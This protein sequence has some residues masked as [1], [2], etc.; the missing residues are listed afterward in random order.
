MTEVRRQD[1]NPYPPRTI[2]QLLA[3]LQRKM[4]EDNPDAPKFLDRH[5]VRFRMLLRTC[6]SVYRGLHS[7]GVGAQVKHA[8]IF[9]VEEETTLW[10]TG[11]LGD[12]NPTSLQ[13][14]V[15]YY[16]GKVCC[17]RGEDEQRKLGP[18]QFLRAENPDSY[19]Y[20]E[21]GSKNRSG[22]LAQL[23]QENKCV[24]FY[25]LPEEAP[26]CLVYFMD[27]Y[28]DK[29]P[30]FAFDNDVLYCRPMVKAP[31]EGPWYHPV[32]VGRNKLASMVKQMCEDAHI[33][34]CTNHSLRA[35]GATTLFQV[36]VP[37]LFIQKTTGHKS[38]ESLRTYERI[39]GDQ[40]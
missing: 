19:M 22:G 32:P 28:L 24:S 34:P 39:S 1:G 26:R 7:E 11:V 4:L 17:V 13:R 30:K 29:L 25:S 31:L 5:D 36:S 9:S 27:R 21:H 8:A 33:P 35:T 18:S 37:E 20:V 23:R 2:H 12:S 15:F 14:A 38:L 16:I 10:E 40:H 6:D 3:A